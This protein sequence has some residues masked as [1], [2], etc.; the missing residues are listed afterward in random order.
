M[1]LRIA[2]MKGISY[3]QVEAV[4]RPQ[5]ESGLDRMESNI[6]A[7]DAVVRDLNGPRGGVDQACRLTAHFVSGESV[8]VSDKGEDLTAVLIRGSQRLSQAVSRLVEK[9]RNRRKTTSMAGYRSQWEAPESL[10]AGGNSDPTPN[11]LSD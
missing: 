8:T 7:V 10:E 1:E 4:L 5:L 6:A 9:R 11:D 3:A 2:P